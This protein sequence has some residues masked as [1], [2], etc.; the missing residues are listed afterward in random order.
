ME[1]I[2]KTH[3]INSCPKHLFNY[4][5]YKDGKSMEDDANS[6]S[7]AKCASRLEY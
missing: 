4:L 5:V 7:Q 1:N 2:H 6:L 3:W